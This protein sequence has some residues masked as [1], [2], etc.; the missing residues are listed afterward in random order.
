MHGRHDQ[1]VG[2]GAVLDRAG[3]A[4][5]QGRAQQDAHD[6][7]D[8]QRLLA[9]PDQAAEEL[10]RRPRL[11]RRRRRPTARRRYRCRCRSSTPRP[12]RRIARTGK[13][14]ITPPS[15]WTWPASLN[16]GSTPGSDT[17]ARSQRHSLP[18]VWMSALEVVRFA[19]TQKKGRIRSSM[20]LSPKAVRS[21]RATW[22]PPN[23]ETNGQGVVAERIGIDE[24]AAEALDQLLVGPARRHGGGDDGA[25]AGAA[26]Q[27]DRHAR[28][29]QRLDHADMGE[30]ARAAAR[31]HH[32]DGMAGDQPRQPVEIGMQVEPHM[33]VLAVHPAGQQRRRR[34]GARIVAFVQQH[35]LAAAMEHRAGLR[36]LDL[37]RQ[38]GRQVVVG[39]AHHH[40][41][42]GLA[43]AELGPRREAG[44]GAIEHER[45]FHLAAREPF[46]LLVQRIRCPASAPGR[47]CGRARSTASPRSAPPAR[48]ARPAAGRRCAAGGGACPGPWRCAPRRCASAPAAPRDDGW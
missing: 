20:S 10:P 45:R 12:R 27:V 40:Q 42:V 21:R 41:A 29:A 30:G 39:V 3:G 26:D 2:G 4:R 25:H 15:T 31:H 36:R 28:C 7:R 35:Q 46:G 24:G 5:D 9:L 22:R 16:G 8:R 43:Q 48:P 33:V 38:L 13:L 44:I 1:Q 23:R 6:R 19:V 14:S 17:E 32:A 47:R 18:T 37:E 34:A 11:H